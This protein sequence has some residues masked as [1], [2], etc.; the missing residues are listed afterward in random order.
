MVGIH[1]HEFGDVSSEDC[2]STKSHW[3]PNGM[4]HGSANSS[5]RHIGDLGN[6]NVSL[7]GSGQINLQLPADLLP[8][9]GPN[10][11][12]GRALVI[13]EKKDDLG[14]G[15]EWDSNSTGHAGSPLGCAVI[16]ITSDFSSASLDPGMDS[17][18][19]RLGIRKAVAVIRSPDQEVTYGVIH[20]AGQSGDSF[21]RISGT[22][23]DVWP[24]NAKHGMHVHPFGTT[25][26]DVAGGRMSDMGN[27][28]VDSKGTGHISMVSNTDKFPFVGL[29]SIIGRTLI[30][31][32]GDHEN[33]GGSSENSAQRLF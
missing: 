9:V 29:K 24:Y 15:D 7:D 21:I 12:V 32:E 6:V 13:H 4:M 19:S 22:L 3:N 17:G 20:F 27:V 23:T 25:K 8:L 33:S 5:I 10:S 1:I 2:M 11:I 16:G 28:E 14:Q 18:H 30:L 31:H 26:C